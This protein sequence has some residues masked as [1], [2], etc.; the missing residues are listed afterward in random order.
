[1]GHKKKIKIKIGDECRTVKVC[2][3]DGPTGPTG[4]TGPTGLLGP[5]GPSQGVTGVTGPTGP[6]GLI[7]PTGPTGL[8]GPTGPTG[9]DG[10]T[11]PT[12]PT[13]TTVDPNAFN[14][15]P[16]TDQNFAGD[17][18]PTI[19]N[20]GTPIVANANFVS[21]EFNV[22]AGTAGLYWLS[23]VVNIEV[24]SGT[25]V[26]IDG[27]IGDT[28]VPIGATCRA[29]FAQGQSAD[30][31]LDGNGAFNLTNGQFIGVTLKTVATG[32]TATYRVPQ[33]RASFSGYRIA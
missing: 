25:L 16:S 11:G 15:I 27:Y 29:N 30:L 7:G 2:I 32:G 20:F 26:Q 1:M 8:I 10:P 4:V 21:S 13:G 12:G 23:Y 14:F 9:L 6:T 28:T 17:L 3:P 33:G 5:T 24:T 18:N 19:V 22:T 31:I